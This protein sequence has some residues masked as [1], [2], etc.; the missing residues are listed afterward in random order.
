MKTILRVC[1][2]G[3]LV[4]V[5]LACGRQPS[6]P[7]GASQRL[8]PQAQRTVPAGQ[9]RGLWVDAFGPGIK[10]AAQIDQLVA[11]AKAINANALFAQVGRRGDCYCNNAAMPR[12]SDATVPAGFDPLAYL[13]EKA[14]AEDIQVHAWI[15]T[16]AIHNSIYPP[17]QPDHVFNTHGPSAT[18]RDFWLMVRSDGAIRGGADYLLDPGHPDAARYITS[19]YTSVVKNYDVDGIH[20]D[21]VRYTDYNFGINVPSWGYNPTALARFAEDTGR[22][23]RPAPT[24]PQWMQWRR[25]MVTKLVRDTSRAVK[26]IKPH[27]WVSAATITYGYGPADLEAYYSSRTYAEVL[28]DWARWMQQ[29]LID[30]NVIMNYKREHLT[31]SGNDQRLMFEQWNRFAASQVRGSVALA[32]GS[33][34]YLN[35][36][37]GSVAQIEKSLALDGVSGWVGYSHRNPDVTVLTG[38][39][40]QSQAWAELTERLAG[41]GGPFAEDAA[42]GTAPLRPRDKSKAD[43]GT[44]EAPRAHPGV[45]A[46]EEDPD[47]R[48][49]PNA[50]GYR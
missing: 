47:A 38:T 42:W 15:I 49:D 43:E 28:Q 7:A 1:S 41:A 9:L 6:D 44:A 27:V 50:A 13:I 30:L 36:Q 29:G 26:A 34:L 31:V 21:R 19:M 11:D 22:T 33:A 48:N 40:T 37:E 4:A 35:H 14:H 17:K 5:L 16:T 2:V 8:D 39:R 20:F 3:A 10:N 18:G 23:D 32:V 24:D 12:T 46:V 45:M 25:D